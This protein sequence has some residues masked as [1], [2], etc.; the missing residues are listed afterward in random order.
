[1][2]SRLKTSSASRKKKAS[3]QRR[4]DTGRRSAPSRSR[5]RTV[6]EHKA[7]PWMIALC[8]VLGGALLLL[9][10][11]NVTPARSESGSSTY[12]QSQSQ[13]R[14]RWVPV[15]EKIATGQITVKS[16]GSV[17]FRIQI[18]PEM[19]DAHIV[20]KF[21][22]SGGSKND[23]TAVLA[24]EDEFT[25]WNNGHSATVYYSTDGKKTTDQLDVPLA[26]GTYIFAFSNRFSTSTD[27]YVMAE[28]ELDY[29]RS[30]NY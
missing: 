29:S 12:P 23:I 15:G 1:M 10:L 17:P 20:G 3:G 27:K 4:R 9:G 13:P 30:Q 7:P 8:L 19:R 16:G 11:S 6:A 25:N 14:V 18:T 5:T 26:P 24:S 28:I 22:A 21:T 2:N